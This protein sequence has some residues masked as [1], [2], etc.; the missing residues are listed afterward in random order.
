MEWQFIKNAIIL[1][2]DNSIFYSKF[3]I[4]KNTNSNTMAKLIAKKGYDWKY[5][6]V[7]GVTRV[8][9]ETG[10]DIAHLNELDQKLW[11]V[12][13]CPV[14]G[15]EFDEKTLQL[16][17]I[18]G[19]GKIRVNEMIAASEWLKKVLKSMDYLLD[20]KNHIDF[21]EIKSDTDEGKQVIEAANLIL[22]KL[23]KTGQGGISLADVNEY[24]AIFEEKCKSE[25]TADATETFT[26]PYGNQSDAA[27][28]AVNALR[29]KMDDFY[30]RC[31]LAQ[32]DED[33]TAALDVQVEKI[34]A[35][36]DGNLSENIAEIAEYPLSRPNRDGIL[37]ITTGI[38]PAWQSA[39]ADLRALVLDSELGGKETLS[40]DEWTAILEKINKYTAWKDEG[41]KAMNEAI[42]AQLATHAAAIEPVEKLLRLCRDFFKLIHNYV[43]FKDFYNRND[44]DQA[45]FQAGKLYID[46]RCCELCV[47][48]SDM[49]KQAAMAGTSGIYLIYCTCTSKAKG[50]TMEIAAALTNGDVDSLYEGKNALFYDRNGLDWDATVTKIIDNPISIRQAFWSPYR[51]FGKWISDKITK[52]A[53]EK[54]SKQ[55]EEMT[56]KADNSTTE[57][58]TNMAKANN[59]MNAAESGA[60]KATP[61]DIAKFAGIFAAIGMAIGFIGQALVKLTAGITQH[62]YNLPL[63]I[64]AIVVVIS[65]PS[66]LLAWLKLRKR[67]LGPVLN[68]NGWAINSKIRINTAFGATL[69]SIAKY[70]K[71]VMKDPFADKKTPLWRKIIYWLLVIAA[72]AFGILYFTHNL[73]WQKNTSKNVTTTEQVEETAEIEAP[74]A[75]ED[76]SE[77]QSSAETE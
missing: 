72:I 52:S 55:F 70:P 69:T 43:V 44:K 41:E 54:E 31:K 6:V 73:P 3:A 11:T 14:K 39:M 56:A 36:S 29:Q 24:M 67:N 7:G 5:S 59:Q 23:E 30:M 75:T 74:A 57:L 20:G 60:K 63:M 50:E 66:M 35:I 76:P 25:Y 17:D 61:F 48:V 40:E 8:N 32:F 64:L 10:E 22:S 27:E 9:I 71:L 13:S 37:N 15:L 26:P 68:A 34:A 77:N 18:D 49:G 45:V 47:K 33:A 42:A 16:M 12:L 51:K 53:S 4:L 28:K 62:W 38:N 58:A 21:N 2:S 19:D 65:G 1:V 46:Q